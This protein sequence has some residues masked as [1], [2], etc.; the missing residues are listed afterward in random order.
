MLIYIMIFQSEFFLDVTIGHPSLN[1]A[2][3]VRVLTHQTA[4][5]LWSLPLQCLV[6]ADDG[7]D[8]ADERPG[9]LHPHP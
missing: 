4:I 2:L 9:C 7:S 5:G 6:A 3:Q 1:V 8:Q